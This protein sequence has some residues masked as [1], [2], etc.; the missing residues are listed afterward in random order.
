LPKRSQQDLAV[1]LQR[2]AAGD[3]AALG[4]LS[5]EAAVPDE[6]LGF[7]AQQAVEK[8]LKAALASLDRDF[9]RTHDLGILTALLE[10]AGRPLPEPLGLAEE[11][12]LWAVEFRYESSLD[13]A[14]DRREVVRLVA[15]VRDW[16]VSVIHGANAG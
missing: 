2:K 5:R 10:D 3:E 9:P 1:L 8:L 15:A 6:I 14:L 16:A 12:T 7:H 13:R 4:A 11:L